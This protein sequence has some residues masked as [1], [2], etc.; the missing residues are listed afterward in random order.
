MRVSSRMVEVGKWRRVKA[1]KALPGQ[2]DRQTG[3][4]RATELRMAVGGKAP[5]WGACQL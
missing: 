3:R 5:R 1:G 4:R 2:A